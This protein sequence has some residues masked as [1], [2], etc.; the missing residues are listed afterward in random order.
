MI[1]LRDLNPT[2]VPAYLT[3]ALIVVNVLVFLAQA[4]RSRTD[5]ELDFYRYG[6]IPK[7]FLTQGDKDKHEAALREA[8]TPL[9]KRW[10]ARNA[11]FRDSVARELRRRGTAARSRHELAIELADV[12]VDLLREKV[13]R[14]HEL[15]TLLTSMFM[16]GGWLHIIGNMWF[17]WIFG[18]NIEDACGRIRFIPFYVLCGLVATFVH[19]LV[20]PTS[21]LP[22]IGAS[23]A[24][25]GVLGAYILLFPH[26]RVLSLIPIGYFYIAREV[27]AWAF[28]GVWILLQFLGGLPALRSPAS[29]G[30][31]WFAHIGGFAAGMALIYLFRE[32]R[33][34]P[35][36]GIRFDL[37]D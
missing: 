2:R 25:S 20:G 37:D 23:G 29:G 15:L 18:N 10:L 12:A 17:L 6:V 27:P 11:A 26:A 14:R 7:C 30:V 36:S 13:G 19:I 21:L 32:R 9:A 24:I 5:P 8:L 16:H 31:A 34:V 22:T 28:L 4:V 33:A 1:P 35:P 3:V